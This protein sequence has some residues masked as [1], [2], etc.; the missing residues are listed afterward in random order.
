M[1]KYTDLKNITLQASKQH[2][3]FIVLI[4][5]ISILFLAFSTTAISNPSNDV[6]SKRLVKAAID[7]TKHFVRYDGAYK[8]IAYPMGDVSPGKGVCTDVIIRSYRKIGIDLQKNVHVHMRKNFS[9]YPKIWGLKRTDTNIDHRRV[10]NLQVFFRA[11]GTS[12]GVS[13]KASDYKPGDLVT[14]MLPG[15]L[16]HIGIVVNKKS[17]DKKRYLIVHNIGL[18]PKMD[19]MLFQYRITGHY[20]YTGNK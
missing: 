13:K 20:R 9:R 16:P 8:R 10:P 15:N 3:V 12:L 6:F 19:D 4:I 11:K 1:R 14:W 18:G 17:R 7:R 2:N 5:A